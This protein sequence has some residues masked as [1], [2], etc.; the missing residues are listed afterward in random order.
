MVV[1]ARESVSERERER[2][3]GEGGRKRQASSYFDDKLQS[4]RENRVIDLTS[5]SRKRETK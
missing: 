1:F 2:E 5:A 3:R 4:R